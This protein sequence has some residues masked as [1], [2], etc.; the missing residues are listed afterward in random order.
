MHAL[1]DGNCCQCVAHAIARS[2]GLSSSFCTAVSGLVRHRPFA[3]RRDTAFATVGCHSL[4]CC[5][6]RQRAHQGAYPAR[7]SKHASIQ[8]CVALSPSIACEPLTNRCTTSGLMIASDPLWLYA[9]AFSCCS[10]RHLAELACLLHSLSYIRLI[11]IVLRRKCPLLLE[12]TLVGR[13]RQVLLED[14]S[15]AWRSS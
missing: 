12:S 4:R 8:L 9:A 13:L 5:Y 15:S 1:Y 6:C 11:H 14:C 10:T 2:I 3:P 7:R